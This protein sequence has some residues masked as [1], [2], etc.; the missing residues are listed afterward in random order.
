M[1]SKFIN[2]FLLLLVN[3]T[4]LFLPVAARPP[5]IGNLWKNADNFI[6]SPHFSRINPRRIPESTFRE[7]NRQFSSLSKNAASPFM[8]ENIGS[9]PRSQHK[10]HSFGDKGNSQKN[11]VASYLIQRLDELNVKHFFGIPAQS[12]AGFF[13][14]AQNSGR[15]SPI[16]TVNELEAGYIA[17]AYSRY[18]GFGA[19]CLSYG[20]GTLS[21]INATAGSLVEK[22]PLIVINGGPTKM[23]K[24][25]ERNKGVLFTH[26]TGRPDSD[27]HIFK[28]VTSKAEILKSPEAAPELIDE[29]IVTSLQHMEPVYLEV[30]SDMWDKECS[31]PNGPLKQISQRSNDTSLN[32]I[33]AK[34]AAKWQAS[35]NP[36]LLLGVEVVRKGLSPLVLDLL[37]KTNF[38]F[39]TTLLSKSVI[40]E[41]HPRYIGTYDSDLAPKPIRKEVEESDCLVALGCQYGIDHS[42][43]IEKQYNSMVHIAFHGGRIGE[44]PYDSVDLKEFLSKLNQQFKEGTSN[45]EWQPKSSNIQR[46]SSSATVDPDTPI[47]HEDLFKTLQGYIDDK[48]TVIIDTCLSSYPGADLKIPST[49]GFIANPIWLSIGYGAGA[50]AGVHFATNKRPLV[51]VG[52]GGFQMI[53]QTY[54][55]LVKHK[56]PAIIIVVDNALYAIEQFLIDPKFYLDPNYPPAPYTML[57]PWNYENFP[58]VFN[59]GLGVKVNTV[60]Q[61][62]S[63]LEKASHTSDGPI[64]IS[65]AVSQKDLPPE[66]WEYL[67]EH[68]PVQ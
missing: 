53:A 55:T 8:N 31:A 66:N 65:A 41:N 4:F 13:S 30:P 26:S 15:I 64:I 16:V 14:A 59:G 1:Y 29:L 49:N 58:K 38:R 60:G 42:Y 2:F 48:H 43:L 46:W 33:V 12:C 32:E 36:V 24:D 28:N 23:A 45:N 37:N 54:S 40:S 39:A 44:T 7:T 27:Y 34:T 51:V 21:M 11:T 52:D 56:I 20:V 25:F 67:R 3:I 22:V 6:L 18:R 57:H 50:T 9:V 61:L 47:S 10:T 68:P 35:S 17:D 5:I 63:A 19:V 62:I